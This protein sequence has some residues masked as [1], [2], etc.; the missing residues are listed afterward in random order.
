LSAG[1][2]PI[3]A[4][5]SDSLA[6]QQH[7]QREAIRTLLTAYR[8]A[9]KDRGWGILPSAYQH[10][11]RD[12]ARAGGKAAN[13]NITRC[14]ADMIAAMTDEQALRV[15]HRLT[16]HIPGSVRDGLFR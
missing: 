6:T 2:N 9:V 10:Q 8:Q 15:Y 3:S 11:I 5:D 14:V 7:G 4:F 16:G 12:E 13:A 1:S